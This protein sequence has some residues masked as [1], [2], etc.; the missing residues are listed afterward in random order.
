MITG[1][2]TADPGD[3]HARLLQRCERCAERADVEADARASAS[4]KISRSSAMLD[5][6]ALGADHLDAVLLRARRCGAS[7]SAQL[8]AV[9][10]PRVGQ[11][12]V[13]AL[14]GDDAFHRSASVMGSM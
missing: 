14:L 3:R 7:S 12:R 13:R 1:K 6:V 8:S 11:Q 10:P 4:L 9:W 2:P 5:G